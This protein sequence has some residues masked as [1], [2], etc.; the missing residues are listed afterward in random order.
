MPAA[1]IGFHANQCIGFLSLSEVTLSRPVHP[2]TVPRAEPKG[3]S[4]EITFA[5]LLPSRALTRHSR[6]RSI[7]ETRPLGTPVSDRR[8]CGPVTNLASSVK[9]NCRSTAE[10][11]A[12]IEDSSIDRTITVM[13]ISVHDACSSKIF[14]KKAVPLPEPDSLLPLTPA[15][16]NILLALADGE[17]HGYVIMRE[18]L[19]A[20]N[21][22]VRM[23]PGTLYGSLDRM[24]KVGLIEE[25]EMRPD[26]ERDDD[27]RRYYRLSDFGR[28]VLLSE[29]SRLTT[30]VRQ[31][32][33]KK[34][35]SPA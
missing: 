24:L 10:L 7:S 4:L 15:V 9:E 11:I 12:S 29:V 2:A 16:F 30:A 19:E 22:T 18:V 13:D 17:K 23:G 14:M 33:A 34:I 31:A 32:Q 5:V 26:P 28:R 20:T 35:F 8:R 25:S 3:S 21:G 27:R 1:K 6:W